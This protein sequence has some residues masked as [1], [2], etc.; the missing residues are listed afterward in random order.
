MAYVSKIPSG[1]WRAEVAR[2]GVRRSASFLTKAEATNWATREEAALLAVKRGAFPRKTLAQ[3]MDRYA[4]GVSSQKR[5]ARSEGLRFE[6]FKRDFPNI[7]SK[8]ISEIETPDMVKWR[9]ARLKKVSPGS[10]QRDINLFSNLFSIAR[11]EWKWCAKSPFVGMRRPGDNP[12]RTRRVKPGEVKRLVR[13]LGYRTGRVKSKQQEVALAF[14]LGLR[15]GMRA[16]EI[17]SLSPANVDAN[18]RVAVVQH[19]T[20]HITGRPREVPLSRQALRLLRN[21]KGFTITSAS[22]DTLFRK[23]RDALLLKDLHFHDS[24]AEALTRLS[25]KVDVLTLSRISGHKDLN[26]LLHSYYRESA[27]DIAA[28][29]D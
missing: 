15:T 6:A 18:R 24:R 14:L 2:N 13:W 27:S 21:H 22:L 3:A 5:G 10:V 23:A 16:G 20:Q 28:R 29:L 9:D 11:D 17:L 7:A 26:V 19:K 1:K 8:V 12:A 4:E 25:K